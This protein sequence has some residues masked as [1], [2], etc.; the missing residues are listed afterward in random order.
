[1]TAAIDVP[2][3]D[4]EKV[5]SRVYSRLPKSALS[6]RPDLTLMDAFVAGR[7]EAVAIIESWRFHEPVVQI[8]A[9]DFEESQ[10]ERVVFI[11]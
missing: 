6:L 1:M 7:P 2:A 8:S 10:R 9:D 5:P 4:V 3:V 11:G